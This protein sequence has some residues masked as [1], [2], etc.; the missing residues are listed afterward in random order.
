MLDDFALKG[1][2]MQHMLVIEGRSGKQK[3]YNWLL[4]LFQTTFYIT[5]RPIQASPPLID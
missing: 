1:L 5:S 3:G 2:K 4:V